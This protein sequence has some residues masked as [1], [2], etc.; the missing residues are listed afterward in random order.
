M[1]DAVAYAEDRCALRWP[2]LAW[3]LIVPVLAALTAVVLAITVNAQWLIAVPFVPMFVP[4]LASIG[5][6]HRNWPTGIRID[7]VGVRI[8]AVRSRSAAQRTPT[9]T[10]QN[11]GL[12]ECPWQGIEGLRVV[13]DPKVL[14]ELQRSPG[15]H[16]L[17]NRWGKPRAMTTCML[18]V[19]SA[20]YMRA[21]LLIDVDPAQAR[22]PAA[23][24]VSF[25]PNLPG[26]P[27]RTRL[28][29]EPGPVWV[30]PTRHPDRLRLALGTCDRLRA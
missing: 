10:R 21:A 20:P 29:G 15:F 26:R 16:T 28:R 13:T 7:E 17:S 3:G 9:L 2:L 6:L 19:L 23:R 24:M 18:G 12:F 4:F 27:L 11:W 8:G 14:R 25:Y 22:V 1:P 5:L 30:V